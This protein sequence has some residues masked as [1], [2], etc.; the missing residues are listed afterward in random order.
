MHS[1]GRNYYNVIYATFQS[2]DEQKSVTITLTPLL[3]YH[4]PSLPLS[5]LTPLLP[6]PSPFLPLY[7]LTSLLPYPSPSLP[8]SFLTPLLPYP[9][10]C[11]GFF[12]QPPGILSDTIW[13]GETFRPSD[14]DSFLQSLLNHW[15]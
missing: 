12:E 10:P 7:I 14:E 6:Y 11:D 9:S 15:K 5:F 1:S 4:S 13:T 3:P 8:L 2:T